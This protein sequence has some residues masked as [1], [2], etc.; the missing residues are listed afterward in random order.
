VHF[1]L[2]SVPRLFLIFMFTDPETFK[3]N[4]FLLKSQPVFLEEF[5]SFGLKKKFHPWA[6]TKDAKEP[7]HNGGWTVRVLFGLSRMLKNSDKDYPKICSLIKGLDHMFGAGFSVL[8]AGEKI[9]AH[10]GY[11]M[12]KPVIRVHLPLILPKQSREGVIVPNEDC[13][14]RVGG[15]FKVWRYNELL[16]FDDLQEHE[17]QNNTKEDRC[18][19][20]FDFYKEAFEGIV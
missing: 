11:G 18:I 16:M 1:V 8:K 10:K 13:W 3:Y 7:L 9:K 15:E 6:M 4:E 12:D 19:M 14:I 2:T 5:E 17:V 20:I